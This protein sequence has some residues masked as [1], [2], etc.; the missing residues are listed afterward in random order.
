[1]VA[2][3]PKKIDQT[4]KMN[5]PLP[6]DVY[7]ALKLKAESENRSMVGQLIW[8]LRKELGLIKNENE[9]KQ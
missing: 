4:K 7:D 8:I 2:K 3:K 5:F 6:L 9:T 1:M